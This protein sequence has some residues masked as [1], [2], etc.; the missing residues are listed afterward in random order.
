M[1]GLNKMADLMFPTRDIRKNVIIS[2][3]TKI[4]EAIIDSEINSKLNSI[5]VQS[6]ESIEKIK[7][8]KIILMKMLE[9]EIRNQ[10]NE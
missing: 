2:K 3:L 5:S 9:N 8:K 1:S 10:P 6:T 7:E 4:E